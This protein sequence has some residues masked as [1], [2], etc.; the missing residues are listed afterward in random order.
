VH[1]TQLDP[2][3]A[4][5]LALAVHARW[6]FDVPPGIDELADAVLAWA[7]DDDLEAILS[8]TIERCWGPA[9]E[10]DL[11]D[12]LDELAFTPACRQRARTA[13][14]DLEARHGASEAA[15]SFVLQCAM[16]Y[17]QDT[18]P[19]MFCLCCI[20]ERL[21]N[22]AL[23][24]RAGV[25]L[26]AARIAVRDVEVERREIA[27]AVRACAL[28]PDRVAELLATDS[29]REAVR[30]RIDRLAAFGAR[31]LPLLSHEFRA[32]VRRSRFASPSADPLWRAVCSEL[33]RGVVV[34]EAN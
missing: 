1:S 17:A 23:V 14:A 9:L 20:E 34:A 32:A 26:E 25:A 2:I 28:R 27:S 6:V 3:D 15:R 13:L 18:A 24:E 30:L 4:Q 16:Q 22:V 10:D 33:V 8:R 7:D 29:R 31:S 12:A 5:D 21:A 19:F 11:R